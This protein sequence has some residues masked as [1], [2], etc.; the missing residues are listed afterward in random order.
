MKANKKLH[1]SH[2]RKNLVTTKLK[3]LVKMRRKVIENTLM[4]EQ[5]CYEIERIK[6][7]KTNGNFL[8]QPNN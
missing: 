7:L 5:W 8:H 4:I 1:I 2:M 6:I 3:N